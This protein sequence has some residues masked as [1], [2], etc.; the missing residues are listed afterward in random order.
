MNQ[1][2]DQL[3]MNLNYLQIKKINVTV[4]AEKVDEKNGVTCLVIMFPSDLWSFNCPKECIFC[5]F[6]LTSAVNLN[7]LMQLT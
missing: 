7:M 4:T 1:M 6:V 3:K 5:N 2:R